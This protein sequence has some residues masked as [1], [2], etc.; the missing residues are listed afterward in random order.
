MPRKRSVERQPE[1]EVRSGPL[2]PAEK[3]AQIKHLV[4]NENSTWCG[5]H[6]KHKPFKDNNLSDDEHADCKK[7]KEIKEKMLDKPKPKEKIRVKTR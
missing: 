1:P 5:I 2:T 6:F 3:S 4:R 7:C